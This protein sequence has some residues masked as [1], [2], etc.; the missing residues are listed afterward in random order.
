MS[1]LPLALTVRILGALF[2]IEFVVLGIAPVSRSAWVLENL[3]VVA[4]AVVLALAW[5]NFRLS[6]V[7]YTLLFLFLCV[8]EVGA[9]YTYSQV[10][11]D[12]A[13]QALT[14]SSL[15]A[16]MGWE[17]NHFDRFVHFL[18]GLLLAYPVREFYL[19]VVSVR[20]IWGFTMPLGF[21]MST[22]MM[23]ELLEWAAAEVF[24]GELAFDYVGAQG[25][26]WDAQK[27][28]AAAS[29]GA[30]VAMAVT[31]A[32]N[33]FLERDFAAEW[34]ESLRVK[35]PEPLG[36]EALARMIEQSENDPESD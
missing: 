8:H 25:D 36:E 2:L 9:H 13:W 21:A 35:D 26:V 24:G 32:T 30:V 1:R 10:P 5:R 16:S 31:L 19:R 33:V 18:Y 34:A 22:S 12:E 27:D 6:R 4:L 23:Y 14:G 7:S 11:Y 3:I 28:M 29:L 17:R 15:N 20:G